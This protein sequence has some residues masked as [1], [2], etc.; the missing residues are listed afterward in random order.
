LT[1]TELGKPIQLVIISALDKLLQPLS[2]LDA[3][4]FEINKNNNNDDIIDYDIKQKIIDKLKEIAESNLLQEYDYN[5][6]PNKRNIPY[7]PNPDFI[8]RDTD[9]IELYL[10]LIGDLRALFT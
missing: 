7:S 3:I 8:G 5:I 2:N 4:V 9:L 6:L 1:A 10:E